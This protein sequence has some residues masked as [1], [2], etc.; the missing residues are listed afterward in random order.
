[1]ALPAQVA[2]VLFATA[3]A[4]MF[5]VMAFALRRANRPEEAFGAR[6]TYRRFEPR[7]ATGGDDGGDGG[8]D[9]D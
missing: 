9:G 5:A 1:M 6:L 4:V 7:P 3:L 8:G 2:L